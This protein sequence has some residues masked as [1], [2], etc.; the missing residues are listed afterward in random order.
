MSQ[1][2]ECLEPEKLSQLRAKTDRQLVDFI[3]SKLEAGLKFATLA[4]TLS[5]HGHLVSA[6]WSLERA[7]QAFRETQKLLPVIDEMRRRELDPQ[8]NSLREVL[9]RVG[10]LP[11]SP[12]TLTASSSW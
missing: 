4:E 10:R 12:R 11:S 2:M 9:D 5:S 7:D 1:A 6:K 3:H 8:F